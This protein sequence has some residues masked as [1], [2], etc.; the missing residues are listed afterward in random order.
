MLVA[1]A[2]VPVPPLLVPEVAGGSAAADELLRAA[3]RDAVRRMCD[4][5]PDDIAVLGTGATAGPVQGSW[6][7]RGFGVPLP[8]A[9]PAQ[10]LPH[11]VAIGSWLLDSCAAPGMPRRCHTVPTSLPP[12]ACAALGR[13]LVRGDGRV[14]LLVCGDGSACRTEKAPGFFDPDSAAWDD[15]ALAALRTADAAALLDLDPDAGLRL[16]AAGRAPWQ[17]L[18]GAAAD[19]AFEA[20]VDWADAPYGVLY[21]AGS[22][23]RKGGAG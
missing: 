21:V 9:A 3:C 20:T 14:A 23:M 5:E 18:A 1:A 8:E 13:E 22:W 10:R 2:F 16:L 11:A 6:D 19:D 17:V 12:A 15:A 4:A 7:W